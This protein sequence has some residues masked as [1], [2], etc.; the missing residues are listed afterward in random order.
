MTQCVVPGCQREARRSNGEFCS[1]AHERYYK[2]AMD[3]GAQL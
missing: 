1:A 2:N 3:G